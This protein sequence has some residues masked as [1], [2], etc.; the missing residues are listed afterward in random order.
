MLMEQSL[1]NILHS[2]Y[3]FLLLLHFYYPQ[4]SQIGAVAQKYQALTQNATPSISAPELQNN[5][6]M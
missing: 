4:I 6:N 3:S 5:C 1:A 2:D